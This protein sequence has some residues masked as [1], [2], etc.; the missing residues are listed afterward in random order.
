MRAPKANAYTERWIRSIREEC[1]D[2]ILI[3][4]DQHLKYVLREYERYYNEARPH[5]GI[6]QNIP[7]FNQYH[8][9]DDKVR[10]RNLLGGILH[11]YYRA[12]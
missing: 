5:Q 2:Q 11:D 1:L 6:D 4:N 9:I 7:D 12:A 10:C 8:S 3:L